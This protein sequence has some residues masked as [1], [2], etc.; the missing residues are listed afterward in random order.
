MK[1]SQQLVWLMK[2]LGNQ[3]ERLL[4]QKLL[5]HNPNQQLFYQNLNTSLITNQA[6]P[7][8]PM[9]VNIDAGAVSTNGLT[10]MAKEFTNKFCF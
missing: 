2:L 4:F 7:S 6:P 5:S 10:P 8:M 9:N 1:P 3:S